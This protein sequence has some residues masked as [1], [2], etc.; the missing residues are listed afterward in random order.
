MRD[1]GTGLKRL[2]RCVAATDGLRPPPPPSSGASMV[3]ARSALDTGL[4]RRPALSAGCALAAASLLATAATALASVRFT[5]G[6]AAASLLS[7]SAVAAGQRF[8]TPPSFLRGAGF[9]LFACSAAAPAGSPAAGSAAAATGRSGGFAA[10]ALSARFSSTAGAPPLME[11]QERPLQ[12]RFARRSPD[13][14]TASAAGHGHRWRS[15][16][17]GGDGLGRFRLSG[18]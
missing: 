8:M 18:R 10:G 7:R 14:R 12:L 3:R 17:R 1:A 13:S 9:G 11:V 5:S 15:L 4:R 6:G 16:G 2:R